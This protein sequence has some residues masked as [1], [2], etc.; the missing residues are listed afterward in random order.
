MDQTCEVTGLAISSVE[1]VQKMGHSG[2]MQVDA[3]EIK[4]DDRNHVT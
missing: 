2:G 4:R 3:G 1:R